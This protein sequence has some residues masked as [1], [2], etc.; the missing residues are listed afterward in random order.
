MKKTGLVVRMTIMTFV[1]FMLF[2]V[3]AFVLQGTFFE[4]FY[5]EQKVINISEQ[6]DAFSNRYRSMNWDNQELE[7]NMTLF[8]NVNGVELTVLDDSGNIKYESVYEIIIEDS[9]GDI[10]KLHLNHALNENSYNILGLRVGDVIDA[11]GYHWE[12]NH[13]IFK[14]MRIIHKSDIIN[15]VDDIEGLEHVRGRIIGL[16]LPTYAEIKSAFYK[17]P[18]R[19]VVL[20]FMISKGDQYLWLDVPGVYERKNENELLNQLI[21]YHPMGDAFDREVMFAI[22]SER[23]IVEAKDIL[24]DY[25]VYILMLSFVLIIFL[26][27]FYSVTLMKPILT[28][29]TTARKMAELD[30]SEKLVVS[31]KDEIGSL[32]ESLNILSTNLS[33]SMD[34][35]KSTNKQLKVEIEKERHLESLRKD[36]VSGVSHELKTPLG[37]IRGYAEGIR[38]DVF[39]DTSYYLD[40]IIEE[41]EK[42]DT[43]VLDMLELSKLESANFKI[44]QTYFDLY[45]LIEFVITKFEYA[46]KD[47]DISIKMNKYTQASTVYADEFRIEQVLVNYMSNAIRYSK[48]HETITLNVRLDK[49]QLIYEIENV[50]DP[51]P[52]DKIGKVWNRFYCV[53]PSRNKS[54]GGTGLGLSIVRNIIELHKGEFGAEN[55][56][57]GVKFFF[58]LNVEQQ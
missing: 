51:I 14:P 38:D 36:F 58:K 44:S 2:L 40:V 28:L 15:V 54:E 11:Y 13:V 45:K 5:L 52:E 30:F 20:E 37:I 18:I 12:S 31:R 10:H 32:S 50:G 46:L 24:S 1:F 57:N 53:D 33:N 55:L 6:I 23:H 9:E 34:Q 39:Q 48:K 19:E 49:K 21:F 22:G 16:E 41:T 27:Y 42:M 56:D 7:D 35:L 8:N 3:F 4:S 43:L 26:S 25:H 29:N 17:Q 47:K